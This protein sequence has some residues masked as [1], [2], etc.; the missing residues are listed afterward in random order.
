MAKSKYNRR[1]D[2]H[3]SLGNDHDPFG[4][5]WQSMLLSP[6]YQALPLEA[7]HGYTLCRVHWQSSESK[8]TLHNHELEVNKNTSEDDVE[9]HY[10]KV[11]FVFPGKHW[12]MYGIKRQQGARI[13]NTL[14]K[15]GF[16]EKV[17]DNKHCWK[18]NV[19]RFSSAW[20]HQNTVNT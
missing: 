4:S 1:I 7:K 5:V 10:D 6:Q 19:Y 20:K 3:A 14:I 8:R 9:H 11:S 13:M 15:H 18:V 2:M 12:E 17:E 16:I